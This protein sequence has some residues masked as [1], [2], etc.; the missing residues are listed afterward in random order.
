[1]ETEPDEVQEFWE[2]HY[3]QADRVWS[4]RVN[5]HLAEVAG[6]L[7]AGRALDLGCG[8]GADAMWLA[9]RGWQVVAVDV[10]TIALQ[11]A[12]D[13]ARQRNLLDRI[14]FRFLDL[15]DGFPDGRYDLVSAQYLHSPVRLEREK[16]LPEA[17]SHVTPGG[18]LL[19]V[20]HGSAPP[21]SQHKD[22][23]FP[24]VSDVLAALPLTDTG[25]RPVR[26]E[27]VERQVAGP[28][29]QVGTITDNVI[30]LRRDSQA[31]S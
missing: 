7:T 16:V 18:V 19:I 15:S 12:T 5:A 25:L 11:R 23:P 3:R 30:L 31:A 4:G 6:P 17:A 28:G 8:E 2:Q 29:G 26:A 20:D 13:D 27:S 24:S 22:F 9:E 14:D 21:W 1:M 10:S